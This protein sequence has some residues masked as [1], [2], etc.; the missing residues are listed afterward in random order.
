MMG[1]ETFIRYFAHEVEGGYVN[2]CT[3][4]VSIWNNFIKQV[5]QLLVEEIC[6]LLNQSYNILSTLF[7]PFDNF[8][9]ILSQSSAQ[10]MLFIKVRNI[11]RACI[12]F[13]TSR[14]LFIQT[15]LQSDS[16]YKESKLEVFIGSFSEEFSDPKE[17]ETGETRVKG[18]GRPKE[19]VAH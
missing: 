18:N 3:C 7:F 10:M 11:A 9:F 4:Y 19:N 15:I 13:G 5:S 16:M 2:L 8:T 12:L 6:L 17:Q 14:F 1:K